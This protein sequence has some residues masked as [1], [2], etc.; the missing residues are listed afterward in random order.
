MRKVLFALFAILSCF[1]A[2][3][4]QTTFEAAS[5]TYTLE[6]YGNNI[7]RVSF[8]PKGYT[9][10]EN[11]SDAVIAKPAARYTRTDISTIA[12][13]LVIPY[14]QG[15]I[16][17]DYHDKGEYKG[18]TFALKEDERIY[19]GG[20]RA[21][22]LNRRGYRLNLY[23]SPAYG[24]GEGAENLNYSVPFITSSKGY[25]LFF[26]NPSKGY[27][28][29]GKEYKDF[30]EWGTVSGQLNVYV[31]FGNYQQ[32]LQSYYTLTGTQPL[33]PRWA[34][35]NLMSRF[36]YTSEAQVKEIY[37][38]MK[39]EQVPVDAVIFD[40]FWFGDSIKGTLGNLDWV[41][42]SKWP[43]PKGMIKDFKKEGVNT[44]LVTE[45]FFVET[46]K[47]YAASKPYLSVDSAN[48]PYYLTDFYFGKGGLIDIFRKDAQSWFWGFYKKQ[49]L[50]GVEAW[51]GDLG[52]PEK[53]PSDMYHNLEDRGHKRL[54]GANEVHNIYGH[55]WT[56]MLYNFY[57]KEYPSKRLFSLNR[58]GF[59]GSQHYSIF[60]WTGDVSRSWSGFRAQLPVL[61]GMSMSGVPYVHSD[62]GG[63]AGGEGDAELYVRWLQFAAFTPV[64]RPHGTALY[65]VEPAA[66][67]YPSEAALF[68]EPYKS[69]A[70]EAI[71]LRYS[72]LPYNYSLAYQQARMGK[73]LIAPLY[74]HYPV[75]TTVANLQEEYLW[76]ENILVAPVLQKGATDRRYYLPEGA[77]YNVAKGEMQ[78]GGKWYTERVQLSTL[79]LFFKEGAF[80][81]Q[82]ATKELTNS[83][84]YKG[85]S[86][87]VTYISSDKPSSFEL[88]NDD[89][90]TKGSIAA[91]SYEIVKFS[92][93]GWKSGGL[94][95]TVT[96][97]GNG[98]KGAPAKRFLRFQLP[99]M[100][101]KVKSISVNGKKLGTSGSEK[102]SYQP[103]QTLEVA[104]SFTGKPMIIR[105][106]K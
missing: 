6:Q 36:G 79:P 60:P 86:L 18:F 64:F 11:V 99:A 50:N 93:G 27:L 37:G 91:K 65:E 103:G 4:Q 81:P 105:I 47:N 68:E 46:S 20:E 67:S 12:G 70:K 54:F 14:K 77:W 59:A 44:I 97:T 35:G 28:D 33:P 92:S 17:I 48:K 100:E 57:A 29:I 24:Y 32:I 10:G 43:A 75:D 3:A 90:E 102:Y 98:Y 56:K 55:Q 40:L 39:S 22:P 83:K 53:H 84:N 71:R 96:A 49:M 87:V 69:A 66:A 73:P 63:F 94:T 9:K 26:D 85:D 21:L 1:G 58:A 80:I 42:K 13:A 30:L 61:L 19:G 2:Y 15:E 89:G 95:L 34:M 51:W 45:P 16:L 74:Y 104:V 5:G 52:E 41:N 78:S 88:Y 62:A 82:T 23:N 38:K 101:G 8:H 72:L 25:A 76:G 106:N 31:I 7:L